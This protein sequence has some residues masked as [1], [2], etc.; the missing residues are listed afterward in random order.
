M[1]ELVY[2]K[3]LSSPMKSLRAKFNCK[4]NGIS[5]AE[6]RKLYRPTDRRTICRKQRRTEQSRETDRQTDRERERGQDR[7]TNE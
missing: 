7:E 6:K 2:K 4:C 5:R 1:R 3:N